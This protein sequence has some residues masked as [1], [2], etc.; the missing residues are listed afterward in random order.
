MLAA[1]QWTIKF[2]HEHAEK[3]NQVAAAAPTHHTHMFAALL[4]FFAVGELGFWLL[5][6]A[7]SVIYTIATERD[8]HVFA[9]IATILGVALLW[10]PIREVF[11]HWQL[12]VVFI[13]GY[14]L[15]GGGWSVFRWF[16]Y[17]RKYIENH[18]YRADRAG[19][20][21]DGEKVTLT[22]AQY[23]AKQLTPGEHKSRLIGWIVYW[24]W[25]LIW[26]I[27]G[28]FF[29]GIYDMLANI[30]TRVSQAVIKKATAGLYNQK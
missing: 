21:S 14:G 13:L 11:T 20:Y 22:P 5:L 28:D 30:Y 12:A 7:L 15:A 25:S 26:N 9:V 10:Q 17:C 29:T 1:I 27:C 18:P 2:G 8:T 3:I 23:Y 19:D 4:A 6:L 16:K 24:P